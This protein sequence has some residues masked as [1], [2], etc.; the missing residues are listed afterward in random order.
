[1]GSIRSYLKLSDTAEKIAEI[2]STPNSFSSEYFELEPLE[3]KSYINHFVVNNNP[4]I[5]RN[6]PLLFQQVIQYLA[7]ELEVENADIKLI[8]SA[9]TGFSISPKPDYG[10]PFSETSDL[11]F[12]I[13]NEILF[14]KLKNEFNFWAEQYE[15]KKLFPREVEKKYWDSNLTVVRKNLDKG[16]IDTYKI[17]NRKQFPLTMK[18][19][20]LLY[21]IPFKLNEIHGIKNS[22]ASLRVYENEHVFLNQLKLNT[23]YIL[24]DL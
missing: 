22:K 4:Y 10:K 5:F 11:D 1:M 19:N 20:N 24:K 2:Y 23:E 8:G 17:P 7:Q 16:F 13:F 3:Q 14:H 12:T 21:L 6:I 18:I 15:N 9:K